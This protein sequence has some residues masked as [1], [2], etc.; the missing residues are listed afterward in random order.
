MNKVGE[1]VEGKRKG[2]GF[3]RFRPKSWPTRR[4]VP[5]MGA[6]YKGLSFVPPGSYPTISVQELISN[7]PYEKIF[8][9]GG[10][11]L[12]IYSYGK[13]IIAVYNYL[14]S[15]FSYKEKENYSEQIQ[16]SARFLVDS[17]FNSAV[18][19]IY[20]AALNCLN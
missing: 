18:Y 17:L 5:K 4:P 14:D 8:L 16:F 7:I 11:V 20:F 10:T 1:T 2:L 19:R 9:V 3:N 12:A 15:K 6:G 13:L